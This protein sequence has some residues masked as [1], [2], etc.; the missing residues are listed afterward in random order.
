MDG[1]GEEMF[2]LSSLLNTFELTKF[3]V[4]IFQRIFHCIIKLGLE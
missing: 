2:V 3:I 1:G 4:L